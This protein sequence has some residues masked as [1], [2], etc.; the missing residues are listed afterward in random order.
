MKITICLESQDFESMAINNEDIESI[1]GVTR[2]QWNKMSNTQKRG[3]LKK[4]PKSKYAKAKKSGTKVKTVPASELSTLERKLKQ[5]EIG[6]REAVVSGYGHQVENIREEYLKVKNK[7][8]SLGG[9]VGVAKKKK[10][11]IR[12]S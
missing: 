8:K 1:S 9:G 5:L 6:Y 12:K 7:I 3:Y 10:R 11:R 2:E 4:Y